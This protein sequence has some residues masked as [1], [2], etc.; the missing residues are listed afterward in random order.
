MRDGFIKTA[1]AVPAITLGECRRNAEEIISLVKIMGTDGVKLSCFPALC[2]SGSTLGDLYNQKVLLEASEA[3]VSHICAETQGIDMLFTVGAAVCVDAC[4]Y[5]ATIAICKGVVLAVIPRRILAHS[6]STFAPKEENRMITYAGFYVSFGNNLLLR[7]SNMPGLIVGIAG[8]DDLSSAFPYSAV[9]CANGASVIL[10]P[11]CTPDE[12]GSGSKLHSY[13]RLRSEQLG[14]AYV[15][16]NCGEGESTTD[17]VFSGDRFICENAE[18]LVYARRGHG[19]VANEIDLELL[20]KRSSAVSTHK[21]APFFYVDFTL[22]IDDV[23]LV[24]KFS[25]TPFFP[26]NPTTLAEYC[27]D[28]LNMQADS[29]AQRMRAIGCTKAVIGISGG[30]DST[31]ALVACAK[32][33][34]M[35]K[36][37]RSNIIAIT[38]PCFGTSSRTKGNAIALTNGIGASLVE[39]NIEAAVRQHLSD[40]QH[41]GRPDAAFENAQARERTQVLMDYANMCGGIVIGT[42]DLS[43]LALGWATYNGDHMSMYGLNADIP[44]TLVRKLVEHY[45]KLCDPALGLIL[46]DIVDTPVSPE[47]LPTKNGEIAQKT[48]D[49]VGPYELTDFY[50]Y[51]FVKNGYTP[52]KIYRIACIAFEG[53]YA[54]S[55]IKLRLVGFIRRFFSQQFKRNCLPDGAKICSVALSRSAWSMPS[56]AVSAEWLRRAEAI[57][58]D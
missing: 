25:P 33:F 28:I 30:L 44:K 41:D 45:A 54:K 24:R 46:A 36:I 52:E 21:A 55:E 37:S 32:C 8:F 40:L 47:L 16:S 34:D 31:L 35:L 9:L 39:V 57:K 29:L 6:A 20:G 23:K 26:Q 17:H 7:C 4:I 11:N 3:A 58:V 15:Y 22:R 12:A 49:L 10:N 56:D 43:E 42:G 53:L 38:M 48:E 50:L 13:A 19:Y 51:H 2:V 5:D 27:E 14:C 1:A 18:T